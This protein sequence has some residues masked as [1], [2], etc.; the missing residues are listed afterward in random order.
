[1]WCEEKES[2]NKKIIIKSFL[3]GNKMFKEPKGKGNIERE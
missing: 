2:D 3:K 1:M